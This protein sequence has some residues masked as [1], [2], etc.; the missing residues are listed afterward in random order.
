VSARRGF[1]LGTLGVLALGGGGVALLALLSPRAPTQGV[2]AL[3]AAAPVPVVEVP[4]AGLLPPPPPAPARIVAP[5]PPA[6]LPQDISLDD[7]PADD[8]AALPPALPP[9]TPRPWEQIT[10]LRRV[11]PG[12]KRRLAELRPRLARCFDEGVQPSYGGTPSTALAPPQP[13]PGGA[14]LMLHIETEPGG[15]VRIV[16]APVESRGS[17]EDALIACAQQ[18]L[19]DARV[20]GGEGRPGSRIRVPF[21]LSR[22]LPAR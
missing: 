4:A 11:P 16:G 20:D 19:C 2:P 9:S 7:P 15:S 22:T 10:P 13:G 6:P 17:A 14:V 1:L 5:P 21:P 18:A 8:P 3:E 12:V